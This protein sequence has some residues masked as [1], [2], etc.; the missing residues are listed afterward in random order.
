MAACLCGAA[1]AAADGELRGRGELEL[2]YGY[3]SN[4]FLDAAPVLTPGQ[5]AATAPVADSYFHLL[6]Q[7]ILA[8]RGAGHAV[9]AGYSVWLRQTTAHAA[10]LNQGGRL[11][12]R[13]PRAH[14]LDLNFSGAVE[15]QRIGDADEREHGFWLAAGE[16]WLDAV[17][18]TAT[19]LQAGYRYRWQ[20]YPELATTSGA[21]Q[22]HHEHSAL[23]G[24]GTRPATGLELDLRLQF[25]HNDSNDVSFDY[26]RG[27]AQLLARWQPRPWVGLGGEYAVSVQYLPHGADDPLGLSG[28]VRVGARTDVIHTVG[29]LAAV[30]LARGLEAYVRYDGAFA[31][32][33]VDT[34]SFRRHVVAG[35][36]RG[37]LVIGRRWRARAVGSGAPAALAPASQGAG[38]RVVR[39]Q[40]RAP[41]ARQ[42]AVVGDFNGWDAGRGAMQRDAGGVWHAA[43]EVTQGNHAYSYVVDG[44]VVL[45]PGAAAYVPDGLGGQNALIQVP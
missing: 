1:P 19:R 29:A 42:V 13:T 22:R 11:A 32:S 3:D 7:P 24:L 36:L 37:E 17:V 33:S 8:L 41:H 39:F 34:L 15:R 4:L 5:R 26:E 44:A 25:S 16:A 9:D 35:G 10:L 38:A 31:S 45:P 18:G 30:R 20:R 2:G 23:L 27:R 28:R 14:G 40:L 6:A 43:Y 12:Y 21:A